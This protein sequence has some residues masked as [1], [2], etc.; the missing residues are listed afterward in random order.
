MG[1]IYQLAGKPTPVRYPGVLPQPRRGTL[2][3][4]PQPG[5]ARCGRP[6][7]ERPPVSGQRTQPGYPAASRPTGKGA[8]EPPKGRW[9]TGWRRWLKWFALIGGAFFAL[10]LLLFA[11]A[12]AQTDI[13]DPNKGFE[14]QTSYVY[15][16]DGKTV[17][18]KFA[19]QDRTSVDLSDVPTHVQDAV[20]AAED[21]SFWTN[22]G[23]DSKGI[24][25]AAF[26]NARGGSTQGASTITQQY[27]RVFYLSQARTWSRKA[28]EAILSLKIQ[29]QMSKEQ[30]LQGYLNTIY[31]GRGAYG[32]EAASQAYFGTS[33]KALTVQQGAALAAIINSPNNYDPADGKAAKR[34]L[35]ARYSYVIDSMDS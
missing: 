6:N 17:L 24:L 28:K 8:G 21:H 10:A 35:K 33:A 3:K 30:I 11:Y 22:K 34:A 19:D 16:S 27:V 20:I 31:F 2:A 7:P 4:T 32:I 23:I 5:A 18:G 9:S 12:Y 13:P 26:N 29:R 1:S 25:R 14:T 15:Y